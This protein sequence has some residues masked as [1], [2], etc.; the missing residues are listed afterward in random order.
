MAL[1]DVDEDRAA[2]VFKR[3]EKAPKYKDFRAMLDK[4]ARNIDACIV[5]VP[6]FMHAT[7]ALAAME[8]GKA[9]Y[10]EKPLTRTPWEA[11]LLGD[12]A[13]FQQADDAGQTHRIARLM[14]RRHR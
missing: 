12:A 3:F 11:R 5:A 7:V 9:V 14:N 6:D 2:P 13:V 4:E 8:R 1:C 10:V